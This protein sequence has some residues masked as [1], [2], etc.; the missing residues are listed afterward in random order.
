MLCFDVMTSGKE[1][2]FSRV[3]TAHACIDEN[4]SF[5]F[6]VGHREYAQKKKVGGGVIG[7]MAPSLS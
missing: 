1:I 5:V 6:D 4:T 3:H 2:S 7:D